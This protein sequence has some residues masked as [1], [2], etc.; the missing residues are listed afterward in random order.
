MPDDLPPEQAQG[1]FA[2]PGAYPAILCFSTNP[3]DILDDSATVPRGVAAKV[4][5]VEGERL[6]GLE[7]QATQGN[8]KL[9]AKTTDTPQASKKVISA[10]L[11]GTEAAPRDKRSG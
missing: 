4:V 10:V 7:G 5:G 11:R 6:P 8:L 1:L 2:K 9:L 3:G